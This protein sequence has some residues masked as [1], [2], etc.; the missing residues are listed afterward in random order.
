MKAVALLLLVS[1]VSAYGMR[2]TLFLPFFVPRSSSYPVASFAAQVDPTTINYRKTIAAG[3]S[4]V[5]QVPGAGVASGSLYYVHLQCAG[6]TTQSDYSVLFNLGSAPSAGNSISGV[7]EVFWNGIG[8]FLKNI[9]IGVVCRSKNS[10]SLAR[11]SFPGVLF[12]KL[13]P[14]VFDTCFSTFP[15]DLSLLGGLSRG[16]RFL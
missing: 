13:I 4:E 9:F 10:F 8:A 6:A 2:A 3:Q 14:F 15:C 7:N 11:F 16:S 1:L 12:G 5:V